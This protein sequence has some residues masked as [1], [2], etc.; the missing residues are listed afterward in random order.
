MIILIT[1]GC[2]FVGSSIALA[3][4]TKHPT[5]R[6]IA[7]DNLRRRGSEL[8][9]ARLVK[10]GIEFEHG[11]VRNTEDLQNI[12]K[13]DVVIEAS[14]EPSVLAGIN[15]T[16]DYAINTNLVGTINALNFAKVV[17]AQFIFLSTSRIYPINQIEKIVVKEESTRF[18]M[19]EAFFFPGLSKAGINELFPLDGYRSIYGATK[20]A[21]EIMIQEYNQFY[22]LKTVINR[23][24][25]LTG[26]WQMGK[27]DQGFVVLWMAK[28]YWKQDLAYIGFGG[29]GKQVRD[30]LHINDLYRLVDQQIHQP[31]RFNG[32]IYN[33]GGGSENSISLQELTV[34]CEKTTGN[35]ITMDEVHETRKTDIP[36]YITDNTKITELSGWKPEI[37]INEIVD[38]IFNWIDKNKE[39]LAPI[40]K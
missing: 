12:H 8:N 25:V 4:K 22:N 17:G 31:E 30:I 38:D 21:S 9:L 19:D 16:A 3:M 7:F 40:L 1:G 32:G 26:P 35:V 13:A 2:G 36:F 11:D 24:G 20:L 14:A 6:I 15:S 5:Y 34:Y 28:H 29:K 37:K 33:V 27:V 39:I 18:A 10:A 23:C